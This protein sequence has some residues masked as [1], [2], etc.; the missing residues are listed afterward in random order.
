M[1]FAKGAVEAAKAVIRHKMDLFNTTD[2]VKYY[3]F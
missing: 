1:Y 2:K 3:K